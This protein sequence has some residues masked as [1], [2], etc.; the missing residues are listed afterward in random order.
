MVRV[1]PKAASNRYPY[2]FSN[3]GRAQIFLSYIQMRQHIILRKKRMGSVVPEAASNRYP[4]LFSSCS[5]GL[6]YY[7]HQLM[8]TLFL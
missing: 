6:N 8:Y 5:R 7:L 1:A 3:C 2:L 4:Y